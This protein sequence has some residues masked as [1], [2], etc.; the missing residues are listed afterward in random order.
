M[1]RKSK[2]LLFSSY[3]G[4][5]LGKGPVRRL[6]PRIEWDELDE[7]IKNVI[8]EEEK[9]VKTIIFPLSDSN[10]SI[11]DWK[12]VATPGGLSCF[13]G[14]FNDDEIEK[15]ASLHYDLQAKCA[16]IEKMNE[17]ELEEYAKLGDLYWIREHGK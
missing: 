12:N 9:K 4:K 2:K 8:K 6:N 1:K 10:M 5:Y 11:I 13:Q 15:I 14:N 3:K 7:D 16:A 17:K